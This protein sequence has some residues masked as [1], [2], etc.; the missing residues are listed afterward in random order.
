M[1]LQKQLGLR[2]E[3]KLGTSLLGTYTYMKELNN[4]GNVTL[5]IFCTTSLIITFPFRSIWQYHYSIL[6]PCGSLLRNISSTHFS[7]T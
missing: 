1:E 4:V 6:V 2:P 7:V 5:N 3:E